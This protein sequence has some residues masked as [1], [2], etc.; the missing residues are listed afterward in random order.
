MR[1]ASQAFAG[2]GALFFRVSSTVQIGGI[3]IER[4]GRLLA[5]S[6]RLRLPVGGSRSRVLCSWALE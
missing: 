3:V 6:H 2:D 5:T 4:E 1:A